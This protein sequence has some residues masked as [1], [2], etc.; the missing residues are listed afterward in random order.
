MIIIIIS[1]QIK[2]RKLITTIWSD[3]FFTIKKRKRKKKNR[4]MHP[5]TLFL[6]IARYFLLIHVIELPNQF[7]HQ[8][9]FEKIDN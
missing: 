5:K 6:S 9:T 8:G 1:Y 4:H 3:F 7:F 2:R